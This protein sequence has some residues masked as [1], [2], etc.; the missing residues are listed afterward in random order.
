[1][2]DP[3]T[4]GRYK[5]VSRLGQGAMGALFLAHDPIIDRMVAIKVMRDGADNPELRERFAREARAAGRLRHPNIVTIFDVGEEA[6]HPFIAMEYVPGDTLKAVIHRPTP[7]PVTRKLKLIEELCD[8]LSYAHKSGLVHR[9]IKPANLMLD[10]DGVLKILDF[11]IVRFSSSGMTQAGMLVGTLTYMSPEQISGKPIDHRSDIFAVGDVAYELISHRQAFPGS[12]DDGIMGRILN[13]PPQPLPQLCPGLDPAVIDIVYKALEK[14]PAN[15]YQDLSRMRRDLTRVRERLERDEEADIAPTQ[16]FSASTIASVGRKPPDAGSSSGHGTKSPARREMELRR[17]TRIKESLESAERALA[18][19]E[20]QAAI[21]AAEEAALLDAANERAMEIVDRAH[22]AI[23]DGQVHDWLEQAREFLN[24]G[25]PTSAAGLVDRARALRPALPEVA[26]VQ[27]TVDEVRREIELARERAHIIAEAT[28]RARSDFA[29][30]SLESAIR[31]A[32]EALAR[33]PDHP[34]ARQIKEQATAALEEKRRRD[35]HE[36]AAAD[37]L[38]R[39]RRE[40]ASDN[41]AAAIAIL[42]QFAPPHPA[43]QDALESMRREAAEIAERRAEAEREA[44]RR[45]IAGLL[46]AAQQAADAGQY[47]EALGLLDRVRELDQQAPGLEALRRK[48]IDRRTAA[49]KAARDRALIDRKLADAAAALEQDDFRTA[50]RLHQEARRIDA[51]NAAVGAF[52]ETFRRQIAAGVHAA[53]QAAEAGRFD[54]AIDALERVR[55]FEPESGAS[56]ALLEQIRTRKAAAEAAARTREAVA[57]KIADAAAARDRREMARAA[58]LCDEALKLDPASEPAG[59]LA[60]E[61]RQVRETAKAH[62]AASQKAIGSREFRAALEEVDRARAIDPDATG[63]GALAERAAAGLGELEREARRQQEIRTALAAAVARL[64]AGDLE[65]AMQFANEALKLDASNPDGRGLRDTIQRALDTRAE[66]Q[67]Q[68]AERQKREAAIAKAM[69]KAQKARSHDAALKILRDTLSIDP[70]HDDLRAAIAER[71]AAAQA[72]LRKSGVITVQPTPE[73]VAEAPAGRRTLGA[74]VAAAA[75]LLILAV[76]VWALVGRGDDAP[77]PQPSP[78]T[79]NHPADE[80]PPVQTESPAVPDPQSR[81]P[82]PSNPESRPA[83]PPAQPPDAVPPPDAAPEAGRA[84][85]PPAGDAGAVE[86]QVTP[87]RLN[88]RR[89]FAQ[90]QFRD[91]L[92]SAEGGLKL[93]PGDPA[94]RS[95]VVSIADQAQE[96]AR[97]AR[98]AAMRANAPSLATATYE[99]AMGRVREALAERKTGRVPASINAFWAARDLFTKASSEAKDATEREAE[100]KR[101]EARAAEEAK[102]KADAARAEKTPP[103]PVNPP[104]VESK[105]PAAVPKPE[106]N[107]PRPADDRQLIDQTLRR[108]EAAYNAMDVTALRRVWEM[109]QSQAQGIERGFGN[110]T[111][112]QVSVQPTNI[113]IKGDTA[114]VVA[115]TSFTVRLRGAGGTQEATSTTTFTL[116]KRGPLWMI[117]GVSARR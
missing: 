31:A 92:A 93:N 70:Q 2:T 114:T 96:E 56:H 1:V 74:F 83:G 15:R 90:R 13:S 61:I 14:D 37:A 67:R 112:Y 109:S 57:Q 89:Q 7:L 49:E 77:Q 52:T 91:A 55:Q 44:L 36:Q 29:A 3:T 24:R 102:A 62:L 66:E 95:I 39:A 26:A 75:A 27:R 33:Q 82:A 84:A 18:A 97:A 113:A 19:R 116:Q 16:Q 10:S 60:A 48:V 11:G 72:E 98:D 51:S 30:G 12:L 53:Q 23:E 47:V 115:E 4:I 87:F 34:E 65:P 85:S 54:E 6:G 73:P 20:F 63:L 86:R 68:E 32:D 64:E 78:D 41:H 81:T 28:A 88:A 58:R 79:Q 21:A 8:G 69:R 105:P 59:A 22:A 108:Y 40:F 94:L 25:E 100:R 103:P 76:G 17:Q 106:T 42:Q 99:A 35:A 107:V 117:T 38:A 101:A 104:K 111:S 45:K 71:E 9:D 110:A 43:I 46:A 50:S 80:N 5:I